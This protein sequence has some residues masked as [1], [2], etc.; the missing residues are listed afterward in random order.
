M[1]NWLKNLFRREPL[2]IHNPGYILT[3]QP[4][5]ENLDKVSLHE[6]KQVRG[7]VPPKPIPVPK[8]PASPV[9]VD[10]VGYQREDTHITALPTSAD[11]YP[12]GF[13]Y[14]RTGPSETTVISSGGGGSFGGGGAS[15][16][17]GDPSSSSY[18]S[19]SSDSSP[20]SSSSD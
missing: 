15:S 14:H 20:P 11:V 10:R 13:G 5:V 19:S 6:G 9:T 7:H 16:S 4:R 12:E 2:E 18:S 3:P 1:W 8:K 17:W